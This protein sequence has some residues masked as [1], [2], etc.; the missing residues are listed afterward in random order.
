MLTDIKYLKYIK[1]LCSSNKVKQCKSWE[2]RVCED[3]ICVFSSRWCQFNMVI[4]YR[5]RMLVL[6]HLFL[7]HVLL[8]L[9]SGGELRVFSRG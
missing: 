6:C 2:C 1:C 5:I 3:E 9:Y 4:F 7:L 8:L